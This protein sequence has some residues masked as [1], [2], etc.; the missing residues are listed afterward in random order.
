MLEKKSC[1]AL[2]LLVVEEPVS[3]AASGSEVERCPPL[4]RRAIHINAMVEQPLHYRTRT[5]ACHPMQ[6]CEAVRRAHF[7]QLTVLVE[8]GDHRRLAAAL[9]GT[10]ELAGRV[11]WRL[12]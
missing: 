2:E 6:E 3:I 12:R 1:D 7:R 11:V 5:L 9:T 10:L 8:N 4:L